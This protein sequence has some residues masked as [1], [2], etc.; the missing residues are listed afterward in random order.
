MIHK[1]DI[2]TFDEISNLIALT[3]HLILPAL[4]DGHICCE[5]E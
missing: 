1:N 2:P 4:Q 5:G 3:E